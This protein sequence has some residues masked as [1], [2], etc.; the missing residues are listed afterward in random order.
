[1]SFLFQKAH[2]NI[3]HN[4]QYQRVE[5][6]RQNVNTNTVC[7]TINAQSFNHFNNLK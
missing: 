5:M 3:S 6:V 4:T 1:M 7:E 2:N